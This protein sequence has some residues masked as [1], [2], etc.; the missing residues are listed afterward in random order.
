[1]FVERFEGSAVHGKNRPELSFRSRLVTVDPIKSEWGF[2]EDEALRCNISYALQ[3]V[4]FGILLVNEYNVFWVPEAMTFKHAIVQVASVAEAVLQYDLKMIEDDPRVK[5][6][7]GKDWVWIDYK[8]IP[9]PGVVVPDG[10]RAVTGLQRMVV[11]EALDRNSKMQVLI[12]AAR[13][14][15]IIEKDIAEELDGVREIRNRIHIKTL[16]EPE[17]MHY[18]AKMAN[19]A[20]DLLERYRQ[21]AL[22][23]TTNHR[24]QDTRTMTAALNAKVSDFIDADDDIDWG[25]PSVASTPTLSTDDIVEHATLGTGVVTGV[26]DGGVV[27]VRFGDGTVRRLMTAYARMRK[28]GVRSTD[29]DIHF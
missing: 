8:E 12:H 26:A 13:K 23:W 19:D 15:G 28:I 11:K 25:A 10:Q 2:V 3:S 9:L 6:A 27:L 24:A 18:T 5:R 14:A 7:L 20:I 1:M 22:A 17:C 21:V 16:D 4:H 29:D